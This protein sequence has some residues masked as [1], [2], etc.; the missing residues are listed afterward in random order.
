MNATSR[1]PSIRDQRC[2]LVYSYFRL[3]SKLSSSTL[4]V[5]DLHFWDDF[6]GES[7]GKLRVRS[8]MS[9]RSNLEHSR[10]VY[11]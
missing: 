9:F 11:V 7:E 3:L 8:V 2:T 4:I 1:F 10:V 6:K 5:R